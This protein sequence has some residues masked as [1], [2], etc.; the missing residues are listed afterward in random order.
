MS[1]HE[2]EIDLLNYAIFSHFF[3]T[4]M[5]AR[6][7]D[8]IIVCHWHINFQVGFTA[9]KSTWASAVTMEVENS[10]KKGFAHEECDELTF[11]LNSNY[12][13]QTKAQIR[14]AKLLVPPHNNNFP[15]FSWHEYLTEH[16][17][18]SEEISALCWF[19]D[20]GRLTIEI[21][22]IHRSLK[23]P[24]CQN[25]K[26]KNDTTH[27]T[28]RITQCFTCLFDVIEMKYKIIESEMCL[29]FVDFSSKFFRWMHR[30]IN[31]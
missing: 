3:L 27:G 25:I 28:M 4:S 19:D 13:F 6:T 17:T 12:K 29:S 5:F 14:I 20:V 9:S 26:Q 18:F 8:H 23:I 7:T 1:S 30:R 22:P 11:R 16:N 21:H 31:N 10:R 2:I 15:W 24:F